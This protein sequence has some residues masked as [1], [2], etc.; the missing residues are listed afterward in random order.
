MCGICQASSTYLVDGPYEITDPTAV[1]EEFIEAGDAAF[2]DGTFDALVF[3]DSEFSFFRDNDTFSTGEDMQVGDTFL[4]SLFSNDFDLIRVFLSPGTTY[5]VSVD[6][7]F[8]TVDF[9]VIGVFNVFEEVVGVD[10]TLFD[11]VSS[12]VFTA[13]GFTHFISVT[14]LETLFP[15]GI[16][17][18]GSYRVTI[19]EFEAPTPVIVPGLDETTDLVANDATTGVIEVGGTFKGFHEANDTDWI[20]VELTEGQTVTI[21]LNGFSDTP[22]RDTVLTIFNEDDESI[23][24]NDDF[25]FSLF[26]EVTITADYTGTHYIQVEAF[27]QGGDIGAYQVRVFEGGDAPNGGG[28]DVLT[29]DEIAAYLT[30]GFWEDDAFTSDGPFSFDIEAGGTITV[31]LDALTEDGRF[32]AEAALNAWTTATGLQFQTVSSGAMIT[33]DDDEDGAFSNFE[34]LSGTT[35]VES[36]VNVST[37]WLQDFGT[38]L[39]SYSFQ[40]Y[41]HEIGHAIGLGHAGDY[42]GF[43]RRSSGSTVIS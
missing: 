40:T 25:G 9:P 8:S 33:F 32:L 28:Q 27:N 18:N 15:I 39:D 12:L 3:E 30:N 4:G 23:A 5:E 6:L 2:D 16:P 37:E 10:D 31:D 11:G 13:T 36:S 21:D 14:S 1:K 29:N 7:S 35:I 41:I 43:P 34:Q 26:S 22:M 19:E 20:A 17:D 24:T 42:N 38:T